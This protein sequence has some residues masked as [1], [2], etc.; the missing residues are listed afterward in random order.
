MQ[1]VVNPDVVDHHDERDPSVLRSAVCSLIRSLYV[2]RLPYKPLQLPKLT[3]STQPV[4]TSTPTKGGEK[5]RRRPAHRGVFWHMGRL[6][7]WFC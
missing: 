7:C 5:V 2:D 1:L 6:G 3:R 4:T